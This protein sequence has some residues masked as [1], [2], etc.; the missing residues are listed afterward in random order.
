MP[1]GWDKT[2]GDLVAEMQSGKRASIVRAEMEWAT[3]Y[4]Q[5]L[6]PPDIRFPK[7]G[8]IYEALQAT[9]VQF[10]I[11]FAA[12]V[13]NSGNG[14]L[15]KGERVKIKY[16]MPQDRPIRALADPV[17][18]REIEKRFLSEEQ[19]KPP[20]SHFYIVCTTVELNAGFRRVRRWGISDLTKLL[21]GSP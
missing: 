9:D 4:E 8:E 20:Y 2:H 19:R 13:T 14:R 12:P 10:E 5:G 21:S 3:Q 17:R 6:L 18:H 15:F 1:P 11:Y 7:V 16:I